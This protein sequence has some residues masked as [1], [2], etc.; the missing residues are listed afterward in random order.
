MTSVVFYSLT[1]ATML[2]PGKDKTRVCGYTRFEYIHWACWRTLIKTEYLCS[3]ITPQAFWQSSAPGTVSTLVTSVVLYSLVRAT[4]M[5]P[6]KDE[7]CVCGVNIHALNLFIERSGEHWGEQ[8]IFYSFTT[9]QEFWQSSA[10]GTLSSLVTSINLYSLIWATLMSLVR[11]E[12]RF[13]GYI[14]SEFDHWALWRTLMRTEYFLF[15][16]HTTST[17]AK[18]STW[19]YEHSGGIS[20]SLFFSVI[21][22]DESWEGRRNMCLYIYLQNRKNYTTYIKCNVSLSALSVIIVSQT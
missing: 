19:Y 17:L 20:C 2:S 6:G 3:F 1:G 15:I 8:N 14:P 16:H 18:L 13:C 9:T 4:L 7:T 5:S 10:P 12:T 21:H 11:D 22:T